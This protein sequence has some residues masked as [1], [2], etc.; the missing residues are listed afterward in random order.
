LIVHYRHIIT[1]H[2]GCS[3]YRYAHHPYCISMCDWLPL[4]SSSLQ[5]RYRMW[6]PFWEYHA[7]VSI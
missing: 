5:I 6:H 3:L 7:I 4:P 2:I 1:V